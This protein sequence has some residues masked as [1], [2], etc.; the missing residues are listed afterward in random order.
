MNKPIK[1]L[2]TSSVVGTAVFLFSTVSVFAVLNSAAF[3]PQAQDFIK[4]NCDKNTVNDEKSLLC[5]LF[6]KTGELDTR[7]NTLEHHAVTV[8]NGTGHFTRIFSEPPVVTPPPPSTI[9]KSTIR[10]Y[11]T[12]HNTGVKNDL[13]I[14]AYSPKCRSF[15]MDDMGI[16]GNNNNGSIGNIPIPAN[17]TVELKFMDLSMI[18]NVKTIDEVKVGDQI[19]MSLFFDKNGEVPINIQ[20]IDTPQ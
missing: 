18:C 6:Y 10:F 5:Y 2:L 12:I 7:V 15:I 8:D 13:L 17:S 1:K 19:P 20:I 3:L 9:D 11:A 14:G 16:S 4:K